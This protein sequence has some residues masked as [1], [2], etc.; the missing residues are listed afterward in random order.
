[1]KLTFN[2]AASMVTGSCHL[3]EVG[4]EKILID[5]GMFQGQ[6]ET[7]AI[8]YEPF[9]FDPKRISH[10]ILT[11]A[12]IDHCGLIPKL[13]KAGFRG[14]IYGTPPTLDLAKIMLE[15]SAIVNQDDIKHEN[16]RRLR[17]GLPQRKPLFVLADV[18]LACKSF[19]P[20]RYN[21]MITLSN[22]LRVILRDA[23]H[24]LG[25]AIVEVYAQEH[26]RTRKLVFSGDLGQGG[27]PLVHDPAVISDADYVVVE[28]TYGN[29]AHGEVAKRE[30][31]LSKAVTET[32]RRGGK[33]M[34]PS[35]SVER[36]QELLYYLH[37][38][39]RAGKLPN[40]EVFLDS[41]LAIKAT[42]VFNSYMDYFTPNLR[43]EFKTPFTF[44]KLKFL[45]TPEQS[46]KMN[47]YERQCIIIAG[48]GMCTA[49]RI[50]YHLKHHLWDPKNTVLFVGYQ[51][52][53]TTGRL[54]LDGA[55]IVKMMGMEFAVGAKVVHIDSF[56]SHADATDLMKWMS[57]FRRKPRRVF[58]V[59][60]E[61][62][63]SKAF[64]ANLKKAGFR[65]TVPTRSQSFQ[66]D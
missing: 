62:G 26:G 52:E 2:G 32:F 10:V 6:K 48:N 51:A 3:L 53:G 56:S 37:R 39:D 57:S 13:V 29:K 8:N 20:L 42:G 30:E 9:N 16:M 12:H 58:I 46:K 18:K 33:L 50:R 23:G 36:T 44:K 64:E 63:S 11:H 19:H 35:F 1:M 24:I 54:I 27:T 15:D 22:N 31:M 7:T 28:S 25:S 34:I 21:Q 59:H 40:E 60:G 55:K 5:C 41:P 49:G 65:A 38:L 66:L 45:D 61:E 14:R 17:M 4:N 47:E 43:R